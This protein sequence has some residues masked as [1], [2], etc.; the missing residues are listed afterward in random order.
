MTRSTRSYSTAFVLTTAL[1]LAP[2]FGCTAD[3]D[4]EDDGATQLAQP[5]AERLPAAKLVDTSVDVK[6]GVYVIS[7]DGD[8]AGYNN[9]TAA[10]MDAYSYAFEASNDRTWL[11]K[12]VVQADVALGQ[13]DMVAKRCDWRTYEGYPAAGET[14]PCPCYVSHGWQQPVNAHSGVEERYPYLFFTAAL[15]T[16]L[17]RFA[18]LVFARGLDGQFVNGTGGP[19]YGD[20][21]RLYIRELELAMT[22]ARTRGEQGFG[23]H[24]VTEQRDGVTIGYYRAASS[25]LRPPALAHIPS[26]PSTL[27]HLDNEILPLN[28]QSIVALWQLELSRYYRAI[29]DQVHERKYFGL[30]SQ[31]VSYVQRGPSTLRTVVPGA[32]NEQAS[33]CQGPSAGGSATTRAG[34]DWEYAPYVGSRRQCEDVGH[35]NFTYKLMYEAHKAGLVDVAQMTKLAVTFERLL[36]EDVEKGWTIKAHLIDGTGE[37]EQSFAAFHLASPF[38]AE[39][40]N[41]SR[42]RVEK[43]KSFIERATILHAYVN[44]D[45]PASNLP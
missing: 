29:G 43:T 17:A 8:V 44:G 40:R 34:F 10:V 42:A 15:Y 13:R 27:R 5:L 7:K 26:L 19:T 16:P 4:A 3:A 32:A 22:E 23:E 36:H 30:A 33:T 9:S 38:R 21:A 41:K 25:A 45:W 35:A 11:Q 1:V 2:A 14:K 39:M 12:I 37:K 18:T 24:L 28:M 31:M 6:P 20:K